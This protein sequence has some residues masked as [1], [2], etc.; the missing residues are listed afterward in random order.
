MSRECYYVSLKS[1]GRKYEAHL[2]EPSRLSKPGRIG[3]PEAVMILLA[4]V[5]KHGRPLPE[6]ATDII[7]IPLDDDCPKRSVRIGN[8][9]LIPRSRTPLLAC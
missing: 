2:A 6:P 7:D 4:S 9:L 3:P 1:L 8:S 5:E